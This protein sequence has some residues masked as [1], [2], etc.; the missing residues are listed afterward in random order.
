MRQ[1]KQ[2]LIVGEK[3]CTDKRFKYTLILV[4][5][6]EQFF[7]NF[8]LKKLN[9]IYSFKVEYY[10]PLFV[11]V[12]HPNSNQIIVYPPIAIC[13]LQFPLSYEYDPCYRYQ[14]WMLQWNITFFTGRPTD[15]GLQWKHHLCDTWPCWILVQIKLKFWGRSPLYLL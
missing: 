10:R 11:I 15:P 12:G 9:D 7:L 1:N 13:P 4:G 8:F 14:F 5:D 2:F 6:I 3:I